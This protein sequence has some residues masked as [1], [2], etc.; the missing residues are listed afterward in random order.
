MRLLGT[1]SAIQ[2][3]RTAQTVYTQQRHHP[4]SFLQRR[5]KWARANS[6]VVDPNLGATIVRI[7]DSWDNKNRSLQ[8]LLIPERQPWNKDSTMLVGARHQ[9]RSLLMSFD[10]TTVEGPGEKQDGDISSNT[11]QRR[12]SC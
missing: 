8:G 5:L 6:V 11:K 3:L 12:Q 7:T 9:G 4:I 1:I 10:P 2:A